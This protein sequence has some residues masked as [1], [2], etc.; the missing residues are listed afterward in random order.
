MPAYNHNKYVEKTLNSVVKDNYP[1]KELI[2]INDGSTDNT[3]SIIKKWIKKH[4]DETSIIYR[5]RSNKGVTKTLNDLI[6]LSNGEYILFIH[7]DDYL[8]PNG[9]M[10]RYN[11]LQKHPEKLAVFADCIVIDKEKKKIYDSGLSDL[12]F[13]DKSKYSTAEGLKKEI[14][15]NWSVPGGTIMVKK[16]AYKQFRY[17]E[18]FIIEDL[19]FYLYFASKNLIG[20]LDEKVSTYRIHGEN[21]CM[22]DENWIRVQKDIINS[23][24]RNLKYYNFRFKLWM[25]LKILLNYKPLISHAISRRFRKGL[26]VFLSVK[27]YFFWRY[28]SLK[29]TNHRNAIITGIPRS[30]TSYMCKLL[31]SIENTVVINEPDE[32]RWVI[33]DSSKLWRLVAFYNIIRNKVNNGKAIKNKTYNGKII[34]DTS[35][36]DNSSYSIPNVSSTD[37]TLIT[38][39]TLAYL[40]VLPQIIRKYPQMPIIACIRNPIDTISSWKRSFPHLRYA[41][42]EDFPSDINRNYVLEISQLQE[43]KDIESEKDFEI[44]RA[45][46][47]N[48]LAGILERN[49]ENIILIKYEDFVQNPNT[50]IAKVTEKFP[51]FRLEYDFPKSN[52]RSDRK[53]L[54]GDEIEK[55]KEVCNNMAAKFGYDI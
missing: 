20:F 13:A 7:S 44:K 34:E 3:H 37:F 15:T 28:Y 48:Y 47:W 23:Y 16:K 55:I 22:K 52:I 2:I 40:A 18:D 11:Y 50:E 24:K 26:D 25:V 8:L 6:D 30:G 33:S 32:A 29:N 14:I 1:N 35:K 10:K 5:S 42:F 21:T 4:Q 9:I 27:K 12:Y 39:N 46:L 38:K 41:R 49:K 19:D 54:H 31:D 45:L 51:G 53:V 17:N 36:M 43:I